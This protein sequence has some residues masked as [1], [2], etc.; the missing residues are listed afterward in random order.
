MCS[1]D[2][3]SPIHNSII[4]PKKANPIHHSRIPH[5][6]YEHEMR[7]YFSQFGPVQRLRLSRNRK[8][9]R[10][11]H[12]AFIEFAS[13]EVAKIAAETMDNYLLFNHIMKCKVIEKEQVHEDLWKGANRRFKVVP[14]NR[15]EGR[16][17]EMGMGREKWAGRI[18]EERERREKKKVMVKEV[19]GYEYE[20]VELKG[21]E[22]V[23]VREL[24]RKALDMGD[25]GTAIEETGAGLEAGA[26]AEAEAEADAGA[27]VGGQVAEQQIIEE[28]NTIVRDGEGTVV[29]SEDI[30]VKK[31]RKV[32]KKDK[33]EG[34]GEGVGETAKKR[35]KRVKK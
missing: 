26:G 3:Q 24:K 29:V 19:M 25:A 1:S 30:K 20:G 32:A 5:G 4:P 12:Y 9:G 17:L 6:F 7:A 8:T 35:V 10:S 34:E 33:L 11:K 22:D 18:E 31:T 21:V 2:S 28:E 13:A 14:H 16:H 27:E 23:P 15:L